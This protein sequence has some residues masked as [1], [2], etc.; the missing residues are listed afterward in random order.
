MTKAK[1]L[2]PWERAQ[3]NALGLQGYARTD[4]WAICWIKPHRVHVVKK[5]DD[6]W[7]WA[8]LEHDTTW[9]RPRPRGEKK[10]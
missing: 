10:D 6:Y 8:C 5:F 2:L 4:R 7:Q 9:R 3:A 1:P